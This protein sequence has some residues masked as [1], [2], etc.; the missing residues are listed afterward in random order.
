MSSL[1]RRIWI[2]FASTALI[3]AVL[4]LGF[5]LGQ[6]ASSR[7]KDFAAIENAWKLLQQEYVDPNSV[8]FSAISH[9]AVQAMMDALNDSHSV[10]LTQQQYNDM[11]ASLSGD[12]YVGIGINFS[13]IRGQ[14][15][16]TYV[17]LGSPAETAGV[18]DGDVVLE[19]EGVS[20]SGMT[21]DD[22]RAMVRGDAGTQVTLRVRHQ[23]TTDTTVV[24]ITRAEIN[25]PSVYYRAMDGDIAYIGI[26]QFS[27]TTNDELG[28]VLERISGNGTKGIIIDLRD[29]PG[30]WLSTVVDAVSRF[31]KS[32]T[33][34]TVC[35]N[36][37]SK[38]EVKT[39]SQNEITD[40]PVVVLAN[41]YS[42][43]ASEVFSGAL[44]DYGRAVIAGNVTYGKGSVN[45][46]FEL[47]D[48]SAIYLTTARWLTPNG[49]LIEGNGITPDYMLNDD[50]DWVKWAIDYLNR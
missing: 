36:D 43:S 26:T 2:V 39:T 28:I 23:N 11:I 25:T 19:V 22:L 40:L 9:A 16:V 46:F 20:T 31:V 17:F 21:S 5:N 30:G 42:A 13:I 37:G 10:Y 4:Y 33:V 7:D 15:V 47:P 48:G 18:L 14:V 1:L 29:N 50:I 6:S 12:S 41:E 49:H 45:N 32:G 44:Q 24:T 8:D 3:L 35:N 27:S 34:L 38:K